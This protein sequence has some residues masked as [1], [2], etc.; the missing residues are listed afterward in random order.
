M[1]TNDI[2][3]RIIKATGIPDILK[4][5]KNLR[6]TDLQSLLLA[7]YEE[8]VAELTA[9]NIMS[10]YQENRFVVPCAV[11]QK[12]LLEADLLATK[13]IPSD[14]SI[15]ELS[16]VAP[17]A[18]NSVL[19]KTNQKKVMTTVRNL[20]VCADP[21]TSL[22]LECADRRQSELRIDK[23][24]AKIIKLATSQRCMRL[25][26]F[27]DIPGFTPHFRTFSLATAGRDQGSEIFEKQ[28]LVEH[29]VFYLSYLNMLSQL[30]FHFENISISFSDIQIMEKIIQSHS[31][32]RK[33]LGR[34]TQSATFDIF[35]QL[36]ITLPNKAKTVLEIPEQEI[37]RYHIEH[38][39]ALLSI[40]EKD[41]ASEIV[42]L[43]PYASCNI[44]LGRIPGIGY[45]QNLC[46]KIT[47]CNIRSETFP[48]VDGGIVNWTQQLLNSKKERALVSGIGTELIC[49]QFHR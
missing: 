33:I 12:I 46:F 14:F 3:E 2:I 45:Y 30:D 39:V 21:T 35:D 41:V 8:R 6:P 24:S 36:K 1:K 37:S 13:I 31:M 32:D 47:A 18:T 19:T 26:T 4:V 16:S 40:I 10:Q 22:I 20:E 9:Q 25:Q 42:K 7:L 5:L 49:K 27:E 48:I 17:F 15:I 28:A 29:I 44:D 23:R 38:P 11:P 43:F 34:Q